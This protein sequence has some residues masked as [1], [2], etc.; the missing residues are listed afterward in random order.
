M[1]L[2]PTCL[3]LETPDGPTVKE[4]RIHNGDIETRQ[5]KHDRTA[6]DCQWHRLTPEQLAEHVNRNTVV[7][8]WLERRLGWRRLLQACVGEQNPSHLDGL[9]NRAERRAA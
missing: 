9:D 1:S 7:A 6:D 3:R 2:T 8:H 5:L 4:Y